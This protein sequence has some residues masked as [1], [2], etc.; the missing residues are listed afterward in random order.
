MV[1]LNSYFAIIIG[2]LTSFLFRLS[3]INYLG[4]LDGCEETERGVR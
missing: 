1:V 2:K 4:S 3:P